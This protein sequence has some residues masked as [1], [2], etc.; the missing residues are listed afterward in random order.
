MER[1]HIPSPQSKPIPKDRWHIPSPLSP[2]KFWKMLR[3]RKSFTTGGCNRLYTD[4][5][6]PIV[7]VPIAM[8]LRVP[9][10]MTLVLIFPFIPIVRLVLWTENCPRNLIFSLSSLVNLK[11]SVPVV[12]SSQSLVNEGLHSPRLIRIHRPVYLFLDSFTLV[13]SPLF[14]LLP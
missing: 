9:Y 10:S 4:L 2:T 7:F 1:W 12:Y 5:S 14:F 13:V 6:D 8:K 3:R 11:N